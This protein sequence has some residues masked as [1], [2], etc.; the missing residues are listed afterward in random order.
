MHKFGLLAQLVEQP[1][2]KRSVVSSSLTQPTKIM[3]TSPENKQIRAIFLP[4][5]VLPSEERRIRS[6]FVGP[7]ADVY[8]DILVRMQRRQK[9]RVVAASVI[10]AY[11][12]IFKEECRFVG[13]QREAYARLAIDQL[14]DYELRLVSREEFERMVRD[15]GLIG[16]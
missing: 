2:L 11:E 16:G 8:G 13:S 5:E 1:P 9:N 7:D 4:A 6:G 10:D 15:Q 3:A 14:S 12:M